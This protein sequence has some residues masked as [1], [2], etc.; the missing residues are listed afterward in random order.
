MNKLPLATNVET[1]C[2][3]IKNLVTW[4][5]KGVVIFS[6]IFTTMLATSSS[7]LVLAQM[8]QSNPLKPL[9]WGMQMIANLGAF[10]VYALWFGAI[11]WVVIS[12]LYNSHNKYWPKEYKVLTPWEK[13]RHNTY[14]EL[15]NSYME[16][17]K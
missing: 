4:F 1:V 9:I 16:F 17:L 3:I 2:Y 8:Y 6:L 5:I 12:L 13:Y 11:S 15:Q 14:M 10:F 7:I